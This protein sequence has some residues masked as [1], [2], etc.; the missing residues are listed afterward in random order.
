MESVCATT[1][2]LFVD[3]TENRRL[4]NA[5]QPQL[6]AI[7]Y[8][9]IRAVSKKTGAVIQSA[10]IGAGQVATQHLACISRLPGVRLAV[11]DLSRALAESAADR[12]G[13]NAWYTDHTR[14]LSELKPDIVH[15]TTPPSSHFRLAKDCLNADAHVFV[16]KPAT[17]RFEEFAELQLLAQT[18]RRL[19][20][21]DYNYLYNG[22]VRRL[23]DSVKAGELGA[24]VH[25]EALLCLNI[26]DKTNPF[27]DPNLRHPALDL[28]GGAIADFLPHLASLV[29]FFGGKACSVRTVWEKRKVDSP[30]PYDEFRATVRM[31]HATATLLFSAHSQP[32]SFR[33]SVFGSRGRAVADIWENRLTRAWLRPVAKPLIPFYNALE[34]AKVLRRSA[35]KLLWQ[36][37]GSGPGTFEGLWVL[38]AS[39]Y[40]SLA[41]GTPP[42]FSLEDTMEVNR[43]VHELKQER[44]RF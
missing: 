5:L 2:C 28:E 18:K 22:P 31:E 30:L 29:Y 41:S 20:I 3:I 43:L 24:V 14:M 37:L 32:D 9:K 8:G 15:I 25:V 23:L 33:L 35:F 36:K 38:T 27:S 16:E 44:N 4:W 19:L 34:E 39:L 7:G 42:L 40:D 1:S 26:L 10:V 12:Y 17:A 11:C 6:S 13:A 21:E